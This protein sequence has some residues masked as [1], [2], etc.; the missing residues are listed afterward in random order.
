MVDRQKQLLSLIERATGKMAY[1][2]N[3][4]DEGLDIEADDIEAE[5]TVSVTRV[6][7]GARIHS[8]S[9]GLSISLRAWRTFQIAGR[10]PIVLLS[11]RSSLSSTTTIPAQRPCAKFSESR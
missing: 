8:C 11:R 4:D 2:G 10:T 7:R 5:V 9:Q 3:I 1:D 6:K